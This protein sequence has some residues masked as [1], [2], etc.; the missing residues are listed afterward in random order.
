M[1]LFC[2]WAH[3]GLRTQMDDLGNMAQALWGASRGDW[4]MTQ[5]NDL[6][7]VLRSRL[8]VH[9]NLIFWALAPLYALHPDPRC[10]WC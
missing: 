10:C 1:S 5:S 3:E 6:D 4:L 8:G 2:L 9:T 7:G